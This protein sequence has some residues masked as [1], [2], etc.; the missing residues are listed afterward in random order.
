MIP[1]LICFLVCINT[2]FANDICNY[3]EFELLSSYDFMSNNDF[4]YDSENDINDFLAV[5]EE[6]TS[7]DYMLNDWKVMDKIKKKIK[8]QV[9]KGTK[10]MAKHG[11]KIAGVLDKTAKVAYK[12][13][14]VAG[15]VN[16][17][18]T[19]A[20]AVPGL[21]AIAAPIAAASFAVS[22]AA[23]GVKVLSRVGR[24]VTMVAT[25]F[26]KG[27]QKGGL[28]A[29]LKEGGKMAGN[30]IIDRAI[31]K[32]SYAVSGAIAGKAAGAIGKGISK[33]GTKNAKALTKN[34]HISKLS[35]MS[36][37]VSKWLRK[38]KLAT[39]LKGKSSSI[40]KGI[41]GVTSKIKGSKMGKLGSKMA[42][43]L[44]KMGSKMAS[45]L[46]KVGS[47]VS[48]KINKITKGVNS[49]I[50][51]GSLKAAKKM[52]L[53]KG[54]KGKSVVKGIN[55]G[56]SAVKDT[57]KTAGKT[58]KD[59]MTPKTIVKNGANNMKFGTSVG[60]KMTG[61]GLVTKGATAK[62]VGLIGSKMAVNEAARRADLA[63]G[64]Y[65]I[66]RLKG[67]ILH[68]YNNKTGVELP[69]F[70]K[71]DKWEGSKNN[72]K[73]DSNGN[74]VKKNFNLEAYNFNNKYHNLPERINADGL[75]SSQNMYA[76]N[77]TPKAMKKLKNRL[78]KP[79]NN[80]LMSGGAD[81]YSNTGVA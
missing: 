24:D 41:K 3:D 53:L 56:V 47:K 38:G 14:V 78:Q 40:S 22:K 34:I 57:A 17:V 59:N 7:L 43:P 39:A 10:W 69:E 74:D 9:D 76:A 4:F 28:K 70:A 25:S 52:G 6:D 81:P 44:K 72:T 51:R 48:G 80:M 29:G 65:A 31:T 23:T 1:W 18:A 79:E 21:N 33:L 55:K 2:V 19:V 42:S 16:K 77:H 13:S 60:V 64:A 15:M 71:V 54:K 20:S 27:Y 8:K 62:A 45:P 12:V 63:M 68:D 75:D 35:K 66:K 46:K 50:K 36:N 32:A 67:T 37:G 26:S 5:F 49:K 73:K 30:R 11:D 61:K 58:F